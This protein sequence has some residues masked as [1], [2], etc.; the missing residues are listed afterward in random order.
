MIDSYDVAFMKQAR[1]D[2]VGGRT[3]EVTVIYE[4][5]FTNDP[6]TDEKKPVYDEIKVSS[7]VTEISSQVKIDRQLLD[8]IEV[9]GGD[10]WFSVA[11]EL[12]A[13]IYENIKRVIYDGK[14]Y[15]VLS[16]DKKGIG[17]RNHAEFV[18]RRIT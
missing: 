9:E 2:M 1:E 14:D 8:S 16:K 5:G 13:D 12:I 3:H 7:V 10:I 4:A 18:G 11:I 15:E 6:I 17:E